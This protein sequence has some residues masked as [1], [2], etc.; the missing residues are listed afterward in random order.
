[1]NYEGVPITARNVVHADDFK[2]AVPLG[3]ERVHLRPIAVAGGPGSL[4]QTF[5]TERDFSTNKLK[6]TKTKPTKINKGLTKLIIVPG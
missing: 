5:W 6:V 3:L 4:I 1:M 2:I